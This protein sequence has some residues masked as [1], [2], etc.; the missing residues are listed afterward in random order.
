[1]FINYAQK[2]TQYIVLVLLSIIWGSSFLLMK[3]G[4]EDFTAFQVA[5]FRMFVAFLV[6]SPLSIKHLPKLK[7]NAGLL[8]VSVLLGSVFPAYLFAK[9]QTNIDSNLAGILNAFVPCLTVLFGFLVF[10]TKP[11]L[12]QILGVLVGLLGVL[13]LILT[14]M[15]TQ[16]N[17]DFR[18]ALL[19]VLATMCY[20][21]NVNVL[22][23]WLGHLSGI[24]VTTLSFLFVG[25]ISLAM[26]FA[27][28]FFDALSPQSYDS[29][30]YIALLGLTSTAIAIIIFNDLLRATSALFGSSVTYL[31]PLV[32]IVI[33]FF[34]SEVITLTQ[35]GLTALIL[36]AVRL[37]R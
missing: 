27:S 30:G 11:T 1:M 19:V 25:P 15:Q 7:K 28:G 5:G 10:K 20:A 14:N 2:S 4:L 12:K 17:F 35:L 32:A 9:A 8:L 34:D 33:G 21:F 6:L 23:S 13:G 22:K 36:V 26:L 16:I 31:I 29:L 18:Y 24:E 3:R 37:I